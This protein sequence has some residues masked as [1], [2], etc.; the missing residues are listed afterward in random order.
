ME[1]NVM[2]NTSATVEPKGQGSFEQQWLNLHIHQ[3]QNPWRS[4]PG[5]LVIQQLQQQQLLDPFDV[6]ESLATFD[7]CRQVF[8]EFRN[9]PV[10]HC[11]DYF[12]R[13]TNTMLDLLDF[14]SNKLA[15]LF[16]KVEESSSAG[17][18]A[19]KELVRMLES[20]SFAALH[21]LEWLS[22]KEVEHRELLTFVESCGYV[23][24]WKSSYKFAKEN[25]SV[26]F[27]LCLVL[28]DDMM[29]DPLIQ[30]MKTNSCR[31]LPPRAR[32]T[33]VP[34]A[35][36]WLVTDYLRYKVFNHLSRFAEF[37]AVNQEPEKSLAFAVEFT[38]FSSRYLVAN[39]IA[40]FIL[41]D[42]GEK[43]T[44]DIPGPPEKLEISSGDGGTVR[45]KW[46]KPHFGAKYVE[47]YHCSYWNTSEPN[48]PEVM[49][50]VDA[51]Q[52]EFST[53]AALL[54]AG[55]R[56]A[57]RVCAQSC[58]GNSP[59]KEWLP[60]AHKMKRG[61]QALTEAKPGATVFTIYRP[62]C[63]TVYADETTKVKKVIVGKHPKGGIKSNK[64][65]L[66]MGGTGTGK[67]TLINSITNNFYGVEYA[68]PF[69]FKIVIEAPVP[70]GQSVTTWIT[71][72]VLYRKRKDHGGE[73]LTIIDTPG[74]DDTE[75]R[76]AAITDQISNFLLNP[77]K[78]DCR[79][80]VALSSLDGIGIVVA[81]ASGRDTKSKLY[82][83][84]RV[85]ELF[86]RDLARNVFWL[87]TF[88]DDERPPV[89]EAIE[90][91]DWPNKEC[92]ILNNAKL[93]KPPGVKTMSFDAAMWGTNADGLRSFFDALTRVGRTRLDCTK[94]V[95]RERE[96]LK[97]IIKGLGPQIQRNV[98]LQ[99]QRADL[100]HK[101]AE[102]DDSLHRSLTFTVP[103]K[104]F[105]TVLVAL[106]EGA[107]GLLCPDCKVN[108][109]VTCADFLIRIG[110]SR[111]FCSAMAYN[112]SCTVCPGK[113]HWSKHKIERDRYEERE[114]TVPRTL[115][116]LMEMYAGKDNFDDISDNPDLKQRFAD[117]QR[118]TQADR[119]AAHV[120]A[121][122]EETRAAMNALL[123]RLIKSQAR[124]DQIALKPGSSNISDYMDQLIQGEISEGKPGWQE[125]VTH[126]QKAKADAQQIQASMAE[127]SPEIPQPTTMADALVSFAE[128]AV[129]D[130]MRSLG[131]MA[132]NLSTNLVTEARSTYKPSWKM[133]AKP[134]K[135]SLD[136][137]R[138]IGVR[139]SHRFNFSLYD[140]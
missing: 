69:R 37:A 74:F 110:W 139:P 102:L 105:E 106:P 134:E 9:S 132:V 129:K 73:S 125:R 82:V 51:S 23:G 62:E 36:W 99:N 95:L 97:T 35:K 81:G 49:I 77:E 7:R 1:L 112:G 12:R 40:G 111:W 137:G 126:L 34:S 53:G 20:S 54:D 19:L 60:L 58:V 93:Y 22:K 48:T 114:H 61:G 123:V 88:S 66:V 116:Q 65:I 135:Q 29:A 136:D 55:Q 15:H 83:F 70:P 84:D 113:C 56:Y 119:L 11:V 85:L 118:K 87:V 67:S 41:Y 5:Q 4:S 17:K 42:G 24:S 138:A 14:Y 16:Q 32:T 45:V 117:M 122:A 140:I 92:F 75:G 101:L 100:M 52:M 59:F 128:T 63:R 86:G 25:R 43:R 120:A 133:T 30:E 46:S 78:D 104:E 130:T 47:K 44:F 10:H 33:A 71:V 2:K 6:R 131:S 31:M 26:K 109:H 108:C 76:D 28:N 64:N 8:G 18:R 79:E 94:E 90:A 38:D 68:D 57:V 127:M 115:K 13:D 98:E 91:G 21:L 96:N 3:Q 89:V 80:G 72:Y 103:H 39:E 27:V 124:L 50:A 121:A 107:Y